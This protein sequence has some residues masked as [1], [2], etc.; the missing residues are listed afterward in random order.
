MIKSGLLELNKCMTAKHTCRETQTECKHLFPGQKNPSRQRFG[1]IRYPLRRCSLIPQPPTWISD[2]LLFSSHLYH[3]TLGKYIWKVFSHAL[4]GNQ[5][6][7]PVGQEIDSSSNFYKD[8][9]MLLIIL[10]SR[11]LRSLTCSS[12]TPRQGREVLFPCFMEESSM[13]Q[14]PAITPKFVWEVWGVAGT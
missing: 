9:K 14:K 13:V 1:G 5:R 6:V 11:G 10:S 2:R 8:A 3:P 12:I 7:E 4:P